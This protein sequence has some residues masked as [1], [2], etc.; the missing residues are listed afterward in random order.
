MEE[1]TNQIPEVQ[2]EPAAAIPEQ[3][4]YKITPYNVITLILVVMI[5]LSWFTPI[6]S[7]CGRKGG[8]SYCANQL[9]EL[10]MTPIIIMSGIAGISFLVKLIVISKASS[11]GFK[12]FTFIFGVLGGICIFIM[13]MIA[14]IGGGIRATGSV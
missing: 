13:G 5:L 14:G 10:L 9:P 11:I 12:I 2:N 4:G 8:G 1:T 7:E 6:P 3:T